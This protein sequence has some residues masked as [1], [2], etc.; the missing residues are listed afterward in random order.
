MAENKPLMKHMANREMGVLRGPGGSISDV[1]FWNRN[2][3]QRPTMCRHT[4]VGVHQHIDWPWYGTGI[5][6]RTGRW[7]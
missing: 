1:F 4:L 6:G 2:A 7:R 3:N 5:R